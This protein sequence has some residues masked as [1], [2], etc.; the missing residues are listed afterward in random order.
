MTNPK[1]VTARRGVIIGLIAI[2]VLVGGQFAWRILNAELD[3]RKQRTAPISAA[4]AWHRARG[5][6]ESHDK[7]IAACRETGF[8]NVPECAEIN[9]HREQVTVPKFV[10][11]IWK[12]FLETGNQ[13]DYEIVV[14]KCLEYDN[15]FP[16]CKEL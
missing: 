1:R 8:P 16:E 3:E 9:Q 5:T 13:S 14:K 11:F 7:L 6:E 10:N 2:A 12:R 4:A 15:R